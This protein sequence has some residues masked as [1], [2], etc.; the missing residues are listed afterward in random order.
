MSLDGDGRINKDTFKERSV[1]IKGLVEENRNP[2]K[3]LIL[4][5]RTEESTENAISDIAILKAEKGRGGNAVFNVPQGYK[6][7]NH[8]FSHKGGNKYII[9]KRGKV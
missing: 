7:V 5:C 9:Y 8:T 3:A 1:N 4:C 6:I 2:G